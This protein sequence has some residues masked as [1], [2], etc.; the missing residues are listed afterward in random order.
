MKK[1]LAMLSA[2]VI[3]CAQ[4]PAMAGAS[5]ESLQSVP[6][7]EHEEAVGQ[8]RR[9]VND[10]K[11]FSYLFDDI[12]VFMNYRTYYRTYMITGDYVKE[13]RVVQNAP[14][15]HINLYAN[16]R[17]TEESECIQ[18]ILGVMPE[19]TCVQ[20]NIQEADI[21]STD[22]DAETVAKVE[23]I[24]RSYGSTIT[25]SSTET[26]IYYDD[27]I[28]D[29]SGLYYTDENFD[30]EGVLEYIEG[31][32]LKNANGNLIEYTVKKTTL[33][34][35]GQSYYSVMIDD[36]EISSWFL[37]AKHIREKFGYKLDTD[38]RYYD[39]ESRMMNREGNYGYID[40][41][42]ETVKSTDNLVNESAPAGNPVIGVIYGDI[43]SDG[44][45]D[46]SDLS[47]LALCLIGEKELDFMQKEAADATYDGMIN[48]SDLAR[49]RQYI[50]HITDKLGPSDD[51]DITP[52]D[53]TEKCSL[54]RAD[55]PAFIDETVAISSK[56]ELDALTDESFYSESTKETWENWKKE[57]IPDD[58]FE[59]NRLVIINDFNSCNGEIQT[60]SKIEAD[61][62]GRVTVSIDD[63]QPLEPTCLAGCEC[64]VIKV[65]LTDELSGKKFIARADKNVFYDRNKIEDC[66]FFNLSSSQYIEEIKD[67]D[68]PLNVT[69]SSMDEFNKLNDSY[70]GL[71]DS[72][73]EK[74]KLSDELFE[75][76]KLF[77]TCFNE[78]NSSSRNSIGCMSLTNDGKFFMTVVRKVPESCD[79]AMQCWILGAVVPDESVKAVEG[80]IKVSADYS[81]FA[82]TDHFRFSGPFFAVETE[83]SLLDKCVTK[84]WLA[85]NCSPDLTNT[86]GRKDFLIGSYDE[87]RNLNEKLEGFMDYIYEDMVKTPEFFDSNYLFVMFDT[88]AVPHSDEN[89]TDIRV[90]R[91]GELCVEVLNT[92]TAR[93]TDNVV[94]EEWHVAAAVPKSEL[95]FESC[96]LDTHKIRNSYYNG[97]EGRQ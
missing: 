86:D 10:H 51:I 76:N 70:S 90:N 41:K 67:F 5:V 24:I 25:E 46:V 20:Y 84:C 89:I 61:G 65:P 54:Y 80:K 56:E 36:A 26:K 49:I 17:L 37:V 55:V 7:A 19:D 78:G 40:A 74:A 23:E 3:C 38:G 14:V 94:P 8:Y 48:L 73:A 77:I 91:Y 52:V 43:T 35:S 97:Y 33:D 47:T 63:M 72:L 42:E 32:E 75:S 96:M 31:L 85:D 50:S 12:P 87:F 82:S 83:H 16:T 88:D 64:I 53:I 92:A 11:Y 15:L 22:T 30:A 13:F 66:R 68:N 71:F 4:M 18:K 95:F 27:V 62:L 58:F 60:V 79:S 29:F 57:N 9:Q 69:V 2:F 21:Y 45:V 6:A 28:L 1:F 39:L 44:R 81:K 34:Y 59:N 93:I